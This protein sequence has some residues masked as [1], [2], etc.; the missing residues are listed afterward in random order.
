MYL[1]VSV[2]DIYNEITSIKFIEVNNNKQQ[3]PVNSLLLWT[4]PPPEK[5]K[6]KMKALLVFSSALSMITMYS[7]VRLYDMC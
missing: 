2:M 4:A 3:C 5:N 6:L 7:V 1:L